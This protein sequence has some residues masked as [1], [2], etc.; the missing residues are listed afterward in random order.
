MTDKNNA[1]QSAI[2]PKLVRQLAKMLTETHLSEIEVEKGD[3]RIRV[4]RE[5]FTAAP[6]SYAVAPQPQIHHAPPAAAVPVLLCRR[7]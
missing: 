1:D 4:A 3:L 5:V 6:A 2:D 7:R